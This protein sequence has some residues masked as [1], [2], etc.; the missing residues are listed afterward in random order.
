MHWDTGPLGMG[1]TAQEK[2]RGSQGRGLQINFPNAH[3]DNT[4]QEPSS[5]EV[6]RDL[7]QVQ[8]R[9]KSIH[10]DRR[11]GTHLDFSRLRGGNGYDFPQELA[12][13]TLSLVM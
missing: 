9:P 1:E 4:G 3:H 11:V 12:R 2:G 8:L 6:R 7:L 5:W 13:T 10:S